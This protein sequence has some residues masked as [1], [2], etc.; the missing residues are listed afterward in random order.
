MSENYPQLPP[1][2]NLILACHITGVYDVNRSTT[3]QDDDYELVRAW[4]ESVA[5]TKLHGVLFHTGFSEQ[6]CLTHTNEF[7]SFVKIT[8]DP[9]FNP[10]VYR[11]LVYLHFLEKQANAPTNVFV[12]DVSDVTLI[13]NPFI[14]PLFIQSPNTLFCG[15]EPTQL[16]NEWMQAHGSSLRSQIDDYA[17]FEAQFAKET[18]LNCGIIG[19]NYPI[20]FDFLQQ[21]CAVHRTYNADNKTAYTG[22]MGVFNYLVRTKFNDRLYHGFPVN[23]VFK[24]YEETRTDCWF[25]HK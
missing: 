25:R 18:L 4:A 13:N 15:D 19:G 2:S 11:Y 1:S 7:I 10:N 6:T 5:T 22:D 12:T 14:S 21:L 9:R 16:N 23:T 8:H 3:L 17:N 24:A 20:F